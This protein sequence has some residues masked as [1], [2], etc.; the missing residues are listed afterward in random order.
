MKLV[1]ALLIGSKARGVETMK[2]GISN[3]G[4][5]RIAQGLNPNHEE[6]TPEEELRQY[7]EEMGA[8]ISWGHISSY[9]ALSET[10]IREYQDDLDWFLISGHQKLSEG[11]IRE[12]QDKVDWIEI[13]GDQVL[14]E[15]FIREFKDDVDWEN[16]IQHQ[17]ISYD[18]LE[19]FENYIPVEYQVIVEG[20][21]E[22]NFKMS[23]KSKVVSVVIG[24]VI[25]GFLLGTLAT[26][27][28]HKNFKSEPTS[29]KDKLKK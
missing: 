26:D 2:L 16:I 10:F 8:D 3:D 4:F 11:F 5:N 27:I 18:F 22:M 13:S 12:F 20:V 21:S 19:E 1:N 24:L 7:Q 9:L 29:I 17:D 28:Y 6:L 25:L 23:Y 15:D 14:S